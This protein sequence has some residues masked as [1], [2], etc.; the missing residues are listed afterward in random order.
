MRSSFCFYFNLFLNIK[1]LL[2][3]DCFLI[4]SCSFLGYLDFC[5]LGLQTLLLLLIHLCHSLGSEGT[6]LGGGRQYLCFQ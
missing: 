6:R 2:K 3:L 4:I 5:V 1:M